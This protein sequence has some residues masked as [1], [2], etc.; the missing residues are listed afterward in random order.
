M[1]GFNE[2]GGSEKLKKLNMEINSH[3]M[4]LE[5]LGQKGEVEGAQVLLREVE[6]LE[7]DR[8]RE[9]AGLVRESSKVKSLS[10]HRLLLYHDLIR[11]WQALKWMP[12][13][14]MRR[15]N[16]VMCVALFLLLET[17]NH[18]LMLIFLVNS[19]WAMLASEQLSQ[20]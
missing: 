5:E 2:D 3:V 8:E 15:W 4:K 1:A 17:H 9:R 11:H 14:S 10:I 18:E 12:M 19:T 13:I 7:K 20:I 6:S 16:C